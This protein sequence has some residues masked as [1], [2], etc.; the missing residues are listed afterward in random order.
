RSCC[1]ARHPNGCD[2]DE[3]GL[4][5]TAATGRLE[6]TDRFRYGGH[7]VLAQQNCVCKSSVRTLSDVAYKIGIAV[8]ARAPARSAT[9][10][11]PGAPAP[12]LTWLQLGHGL[13]MAP[14]WPPSPPLHRR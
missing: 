4:N 11:P 6:A 12:R 10:D 13:R 14:E 7:T 9:C 5:R 2:G 1:P 8:S 3:T